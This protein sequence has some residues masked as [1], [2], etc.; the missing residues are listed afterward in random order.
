MQMNMGMN[1][2]RGT[3][4]RVA[5]LIYY[6]SIEQHAL[7]LRPYNVIASKEAL[8][9]MDNVIDQ[10]AGQKFTT[11]T[12]K[13]ISSHILQPSG[14]P[15]ETAI[16]TNFLSEARYE[17][18]L[19]IIHTQPIF[20]IKKRYVYHGHTNGAGIGRT[21][22]APEMEHIIDSV[23]VTTI[24]VEGDDLA[25][26]PGHEILDDT[27]DIIR[28]MGAMEISYQRPRDVLSDINLS[29]YVDD[30]Q[31]RSALY[32]GDENATNVVGINMASTIN[33]ASGRLEAS[34]FQ[35]HMSATYLARI[36]E[37]GVVRA[38]EEEFNISNDDIFSI[39]DHGGLKTDYSDR[40][41]KEATPAGDAF[42]KA[43]KDI[44]GKVF[45]TGTFQFQTLRTIDPEGTN[46]NWYVAHRT[47][48][49]VNDP[50][51]NTP[52]VGEYWNGQ[53]PVTSMAHSVIQEG[54]ALARR[55]L[56]DNVT[57]FIDNTTGVVFSAEMQALVTS[58][59]SY[60][61]ISGVDEM[62]MAEMFKNRFFSE[63]Y[64]SRTGMGSIPFVMDL[65]IVKH[66]VSKVRISYAGF[67]EK[68]YTL[69]TTYASYIAPVINPDFGT[70]QYNVEIMKN[71]IGKAADA[72]SLKPAQNIYMG[73]QPL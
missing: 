40:L 37:Q 11:D 26:I 57:I 23:S 65:Y 27:Y 70:K 44:E 68:W 19:D 3:T 28:D 55:C 71:L 38:K 53:D 62:R 16:N 34:S 2:P 10:N 31:S 32:V 21:D 24:Q 64:A 52:S 51:A 8:D 29:R 33:S 25:G 69:P 18:R 72:S 41:A 42:L 59:K 73:H 43:C 45:A 22:V 49:G 20:G 4:L 66:G 46:N 36:I 56:L 67:P 5:R 13:D 54:M 48:G 50:L 17:F 35:N 7:Y 1:T 15:Y 58:A 47:Y 9:H 6:P 63:V 12:F 14:V 39:A 30:Q 60:L 61:N